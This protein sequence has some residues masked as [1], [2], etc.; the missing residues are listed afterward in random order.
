MPDDEPEDNYLLAALPASIGLFYTDNYYSFKTALS[1]SEHR[2][3]SEKSKQAL[4]WRPKPF[5]F[6]F[7]VQNVNQKGRLIA[8]ENKIRG[9][10]EPLQH[11]SIFCSQYSFVFCKIL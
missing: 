10:P 6:E 11:G 2:F 8:Q 7:R 4:S 1:F 3:L 5:Y 9:Y